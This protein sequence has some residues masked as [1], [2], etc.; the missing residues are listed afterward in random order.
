MFGGCTAGRH[1]R[2]EKQIAGDVYPLST[3]AARA[4]AA[5]RVMHPPPLRLA[6]QHKAVWNEAPF[7]GGPPAATGIQ[8]SHAYRSTGLGD[9]HR[10]NCKHAPASAVLQAGYLLYLQLA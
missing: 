5:E 2:D 6:A 8:L 4:A 1:E 7:H 9:E 3:S 10:R